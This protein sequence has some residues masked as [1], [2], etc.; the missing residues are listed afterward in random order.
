MTIAIC[1]GSSCHLKG[2]EEL[3]G[4]FEKAVAEHGLDNQIELVGS[5]CLCR[6]NRDGVT[7]KVDDDV[8]PGIN[9][10]NFGLFFR[11]VILEKVKK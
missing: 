2:S 10:E 1:I 8:Y 7:V 11:D 5:F 9:R 6:C 3:V 4:M